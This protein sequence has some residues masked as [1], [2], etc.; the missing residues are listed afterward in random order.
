MDF[1]TFTQIDTLEEKQQKFI[2]SDED[3]L[4]STYSSGE[5]FMWAAVQ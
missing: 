5:N 3:Q 4:N 1:R 2:H